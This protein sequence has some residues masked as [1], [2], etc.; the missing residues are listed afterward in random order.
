M[1]TIL[2]QNTVRLQ[3]DKSYKRPKKTLTDSLQTKKEIIKKLQGYSQVS[4][5][6]KIPIGSHVRYITWKNGAQ[7]F[8]IGG[9]VRKVHDKYVV[10][11]SKEL[12]WSVQRY[13][14][15]KKKKIFTTLFFKKKTKLDLCE[16]A[17][18]QQQLEIQELKK[19]IKHKKCLK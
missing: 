10:L 12:S 18:I 11:A 1:P 6:L 2:K 8:C 16:H 5:I 14:Y 7:R 3:Q 17:L 13:H 15:S 4:N 9:W 19:F